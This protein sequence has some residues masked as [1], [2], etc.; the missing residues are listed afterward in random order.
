[1]SCINIDSSYCS[2]HVCFLKTYYEISGCIWQ[3]LMSDNEANTVVCRI[4]VNLVFL[5]QH[6]HLGNNKWREII[7]I[8]TYITVHCYWCNQDIYNL[9]KPFIWGITSYHHCHFFSSN[10][11]LPSWI[12]I[13]FFGNILIKVFFFTIWEIFNGYSNHAFLMW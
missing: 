2:I 8:S 10:I 5:V 4:Q 1:M 6:L 13:T 9:K 7:S 12:H 3:L 11:P